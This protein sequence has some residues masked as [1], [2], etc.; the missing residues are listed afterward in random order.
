MALFT[1]HFF[2]KN[3]L[4]AGGGLLEPRFLFGRF[5]IAPAGGGGG[6][7]FLLFVSFC[8]DGSVI[9][10]TLDG[11][12]SFA[13]AFFGIGVGVELD[14][15]VAC[16]CT[17]TSGAGAGAAMFTTS[18]VTGSTTSSKTSLGDS[19]GVD[20]DSVPGLSFFGSRL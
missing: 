7:F 11:A 13:T 6:D 8:D 20:C 4:G 14:A 12:R 15:A 5:V 9:L 17:G 2:L 16:T 1:L 10:S 19:S 18:F 3:P